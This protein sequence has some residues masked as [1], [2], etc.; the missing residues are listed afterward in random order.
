MTSSKPTKPS[1]ATRIV[2]M[3]RG[4]GGLIVD[5]LKER[6]SDLHPQTVNSTTNTLV[7]RGILRDSGERRQGRA[8]GGRP[9]TVYVFEPKPKPLASK[10]C[11]GILSGRL[12][13]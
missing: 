13:P 12:R 8:E 4:A 1:T 7:K 9:S 3:V 2:E 5:E 10:S 11:S 6:L